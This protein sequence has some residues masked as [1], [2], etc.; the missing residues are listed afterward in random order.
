MK[1]QLP[2][3]LWLQ[4]GATRKGVLDLSLESPG[5]ALA[6]RTVP[7]RSLSS[8]SQLAMSA[9]GS[10]YVEVY[11]GTRTDCTV[12]VWLPSSCPLASLLV[13]LRWSTAPGKGGGE[14]SCQRLR[15]IHAGGAGTWL[16]VVHSPCSFLPALHHCLRVNCTVWHGGD[17]GLQGLAPSTTCRFTLLAANSIGKSP[18][19]P[20]T[21]VTTC[22]RPSHVRLC[23]PADCRRVPR[24]G[25]RIGVCSF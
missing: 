22:L 19:S 25:I 7:F 14:P 11:K 16:D 10:R 20:V 24:S 18:W 15:S 13:C 2:K 8:S 23:V 9:S 17:G 12:T 6:A 3:K 1:Y 4:C 21:T 5:L